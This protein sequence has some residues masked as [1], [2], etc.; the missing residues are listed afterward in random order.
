MQENELQVIELKKEIAELK[1]K[2]EKKRIEDHDCVVALLDAMRKTTLLMDSENKKLF[3]ENFDNCLTEKNIRIAVIING[4][5][6]A[7]FSA[8]KG[9][10][11]IKIISN[12]ACST[13]Q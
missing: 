7:L 9:E 2:L 12:E 13:I 3:Y 8:G 11:T 4:R 5:E 6:N 1:D 10:K